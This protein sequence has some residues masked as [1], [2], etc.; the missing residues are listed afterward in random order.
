MFNQMP[1]QFG[2][3]GAGRVWAWVFGRLG[4]GRRWGY[5]MGALPSWLRCRKLWAVSSRA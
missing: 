5:S 3:P 1:I 2:L 4:Q